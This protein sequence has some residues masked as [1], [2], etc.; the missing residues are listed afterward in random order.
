MR[1]CSTPHIVPLLAAGSADGTLFYTMPLIEGESLR[2]RIARGPLPIPDVIRILREIADGLAYAHA[3]GVVHRDVKPGNVL[4][5]GGHALVAD[6]GV[7]KALSNA[8]S[9]PTLT[10]VGV[11]VGT[12]TYMAPE[13]GTAEG[14]ADHRA[15][16]Y[17]LGA[18][19]Y[20]MLAGRPPFTATNITQL[21]VAHATA[22]PV[23][24]TD[25][26]A[27]VPH[28]LA[29]LVMRCL[30]KVPNDRPSSAAEIRDLLEVT[31]TP[32]SE[33]ALRSLAVLPPRAHRVK[34][35][36][37]IASIAAVAAATM[38][39]Y[40]VY[41][42]RSELDP[43]RVVVAPVQSGDTNA[44]LEQVGTMAA[45]WITRGL[46]ETGL[47][48]PVPATLKRDATG[49]VIPS[50]LEPAALANQGREL[51]AGHVISIAVYVEGDSVQFHA[52]LLDAANGRVIASVAPAIGSR[53]DPMAAVNVLRTRVLVALAAVSP[54]EVVGMTSTEAPPSYAAYREFLLGEEAHNIGAFEVTIEHD[55]RAV[56]LDS[57]YL[58]PLVRMAYAFANLDRCAETDSVGRILNAKRDR[59]AAYDGYYLDRIL[60][61]CRGDQ[62][63]A[64]LAAKRMA[65]VA[66]H[67]SSAKYTAARSALWINHPRE[68][69][70]AL[71]QLDWKKP[72]ISGYYRDLTNAL[73]KLG[74]HKRELE[75]A[76]LYRQ[77]LTGSLLPVQ[78]YVE[79]LSALGRADEVL[80]T[81][82]AS[83][84]M[85]S[86]EKVASPAA[87]ALAASRE[88]AAHGNPS[89]GRRVALDVVEWLRG[90]ATSDENEQLMLMARFH[91]GQFAEAYPIA[92][93]LMAA[94]PE[95]WEY[96]TFAGVIAA[97]MGD[98]VEAERL[99]RILG[100]LQGPYLTGANFYGQAAIAAALGEKSRAVTLL[101]EA[102]R[103]GGSDIQT[104][105]ADPFFLS[106]HGYPPYEELMKP[107][108]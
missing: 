27:D 56:A 90:R 40:R 6:F 32:S 101:R 49:K 84:A 70:E 34:A 39:G 7:A 25:R 23:P 4:L 37:I 67:S 11:A 13:Q 76:Q 44:Q 78:A 15:D 92:K 105:D 95:N 96:L 51:D 45:D 72:H 86:I 80:K 54:S 107:A 1:S 79:A 77:R 63:A 106:L 58:A 29:T 62:S 33:R 97:A 103:K 3:H 75:V 35:V 81:V 83:F 22:S 5:T 82:A 59:L 98:R 28:W 14:S 31:P 100:E 10:T 8:A 20:E 85:S 94:H 18:V 61:R 69:A 36:V 50:E 104:D 52:K 19:A 48:D 16:I 108:G 64:Y 2:E 26:R 60:A 91:A 73:H 99:A 55:R 42:G 68:A 30:E 21:L 66:P 53:N 57:T 41:S 12:P 74:K 102:I 71:E 47:A 87:V 88:L 93:R 38:I 43:Y 46:T 9:A 89:A 17:S 65:A 24:V